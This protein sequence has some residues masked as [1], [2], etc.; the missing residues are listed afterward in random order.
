MLLSGQVPQQ[1]AAKVTCFEISKILSVWQFKQCCTG[2][3]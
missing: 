3:K 2:G 1:A